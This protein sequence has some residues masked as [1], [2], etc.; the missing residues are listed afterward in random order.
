MTDP[1]REAVQELKEEMVA[2]RRELHMH[3]E[4][5]FEE[6]RTAGRVAE[7]LRSLGYR[8][9]TG[10]AKTGV[11]GV[12][13]GSG[14]GPTVMVRAD[15]DALPIQEVAGRPYG[16]RVP[17]KMHACGH[18]GH[19]AIAVALAEVLARF[20][21][22]L[23]GRVVFAFQPAEEVMRGARAMLEEGLMETYR[24]DRVVGLHLYSLMPVGQVGVRA[25]T[26]WA[27]ADE[28]RFVVHGQSSHGALPHLGVD[29]VALTAVVVSALQLLVS[30]ETPPT[31][32][33]VLS[34]GTVQG[35]TAFNILA[36]RVEMTGT[37]RTMD[38]AVQARLLERIREVV[39]GV[40]G[41]L[42]GRGEV[43]HLNTCP[44]VVNDPE[45]A[46]RVRQ[47]S[48]QVVGPEHT[49]EVPP[50]TVSDDMALFLKS[51]PGCYFLVGCANPARGIG[52]PHHS[53]EFDIDEDALPIGCEV[54]AR[55][56]LSYL[57]AQG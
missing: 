8:V 42:R 23:R 21:D 53:P 48:L 6:E 7:R 32:P 55:T 26:L 29:A 16:S 56:V 17:G 38:E 25:G 46:E 22:R 31:Q 1:I 19:T 27:S 35:G 13:E 41:A 39:E 28:L 45:V 54:L 11:V 52:A 37:L 34:L 2:F 43:H 24:P 12:L 15:M 47:A 57:E 10:I 50:A 40:A 33:V 4:T 14:P 51:A 44:P 30:R 36:E 9:Q 3:P 18:D 49:V 20:R 5:A